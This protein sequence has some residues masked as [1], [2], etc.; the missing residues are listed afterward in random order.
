ME[1]NESD[2]KYPK[3]KILLVDLPNK[4]FNGLK[5][6]GYN[7]S[8][9]TFG[10]PYKVDA[11]NGIIPISIEYDLPNHTEQEIIII[12]LLHSKILEAPTKEVELY[13]GQKWWW[14]NCEHGIIDYSSY[15]KTMRREE[16]DRILTHGG[17][18][19]IFAGPKKFDE[20]IY[21]V[22]G[23][24]G[25][26][27]IFEKDDYNNWSFLSVLSKIMI[28]SDSGTEISIKKNNHPLNIFLNRYFKNSE[29][30][31]TFSVADYHFREERWISLMHSKY[32]ECVA[33][34]IPPGNGDKGW[35][36]IL[37]QISKTSDLILS[38]INEVLPD[39]SSSLFPYAE[40]RNWIDNDDYALGSVLKLKAEKNTVIQKSKKKIK[41]INQK[42]L[43]DKN[44][45]D[46]I[47]RIIT[48]T[49]DDLVD[50]IEKCLKFI[51]FKNVQN[52][53]KKLENNGN[54][55][56]QED[57]RICDQSPLLLE[58]KGITGYPSE[59]DMS[60]VSRYVLRRIKDWNRTD[61]RG[62]SI[63]NHY[64]NIPALERDDAFTEPQ[65]KDAENSDITILT[66]WDLFLLIKGSIEWNWD[67]KNI[68]NLFYKSGR[69]SK[70]P[71]HYKPI[72][73]VFKYWS[74]AEAI[75]IDLNNKLCKGDRIG[76]FLQNMFLEED[77]LSLKLDGNDVKEVNSKEIAGI[78]TIY[79]KDVLK[80]G[81]VVYKIENL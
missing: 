32:D 63:I 42:I 72:G 71:S 69:M 54:H 21:G 66:T 81:T 33:G 60:Q 22:E 53:D 80:K 36:L 43:D 18:F 25:R 55:R 75:S 24:Y 2:P 31:A 73:K 70:V 3:P 4:V 40:G 35:I 14:G 7:V 29:Y 44:N 77:V 26:I 56:K 19:V 67:T 1:N 16:F 17:I 9:G 28:N 5:S 49:G 10:I 48:G 41:E 64:R 78:K 8:Q 74:Q 52:I 68:R 34:L 50:D 27:E 38:L 30:F 13:E 45:F 46:F 79:S 51:G 61:V 58:V 37:P 20:I 6:A 11:E 12:D 76:Y 62:V 59:D 23:N 39:L 65:I 47:Y 57:L 15:V